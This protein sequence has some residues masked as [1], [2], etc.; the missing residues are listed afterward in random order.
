MKRVVSIEEKLEELRNK[1]L[2]DFI[3]PPERLRRMK[4]TFK[5][6]GLS[7][8]EVDKR[9]LEVCLTIKTSEIQ[10]LEKEKSNA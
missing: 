1:K 2:L 5:R 6:A 10:K 7:D 8:T 3:S 4:E 9:I